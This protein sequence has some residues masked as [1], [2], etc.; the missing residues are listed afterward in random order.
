MST[1]PDLP[2]TNLTPEEEIYRDNILDHYRDPHN[3]GILLEYHIKHHENNPLCGD[4]I[5]VYIEI[6]KQQHIKDIRYEGHGCAIS[7]AAMSMLSDEIKG[8]SLDQIL[9][10]DKKTILTML[11]IPIGVVRMKCALLSLRTIQKG[12]AHYQKS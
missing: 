11:G 9:K 12:I 5:T 7:Q 10:L 6:D 8:K 1:Y 4:E 3:T 2:S